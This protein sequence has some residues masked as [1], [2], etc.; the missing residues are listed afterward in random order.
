MANLC[1]L[2]QLVFHTS[3]KKKAMFFFLARNI[4][5]NTSPCDLQSAVIYS[6]NMTGTGFF[7]SMFSMSSKKPISWL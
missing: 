3:N 5:G 7:K 1:A 2:V 6:K 4:S